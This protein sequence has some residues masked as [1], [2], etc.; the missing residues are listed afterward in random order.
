[1]EE[2]SFDAFDRLIARGGTTY[3][4]DALDRVVARNGVGGF[5]YAGL[6]IEP[7]SD[8]A[9]V[10]GR[11]PG[12]ELLAWSD[13]DTT[14]LAVSDRHG[15]VIGGLPV[16]GAALTG[17]RAYDP[18]GQVVD[19]AG[20]TGIIGFQGDWTD[21]DTGMTNMG[22][23]WYDPASAAF[24]SRDDIDLPS[25]PSILTN[26]YTYGAGAPTNFIDPD[27][28]IPW[29]LVLLALL[30]RG[31]SGCT[32][33][34]TIEADVQL[35]PHYTPIP[36]Y[37]DGNTWSGSSQHNI[38]RTSA[39]AS[40]N[41]GPGSQ[42]IGGP[43]TG[44]RGY[45]IP[46]PPP[47]PDPAIWARERNRDDAIENPTPMPDGWDD[48]W[49]G[50]G[51]DAPVSSSPSVPA[52]EV[53]DLFDRV[54]DV[55]ESYDRLYRDLLDSAGSLITNI[56]LHDSA[57]SEVSY[58]DPTNLVGPADSCD[59]SNSFAAGTEVLMADGSTKPIED[60]EVGDEVLA[61]DPTTG[62]TSVQPV[63]ATIVGDGVKHLVDITITTEDGGT[64]TI[65]ATA[66]HP[67]WV[68]DL[69][70]WVNA[71]DLEPGHRFET[72]DHRD[73]SV[74][75][76]DAY[77]APRQVRNLTIDRLH[78]YYVVAGRTQ[79]LVHN[80]G[81]CSDWSPRYE[82][83]GDLA[84]RYT[85]GQATRD[86]ASQWYHEELSND[87]LLDSINNADEGDGIFVSRGGTILGGHH[88]WDEVL[89]R[90]NDGRID[91]GTSIRV[92]VY[93]GGW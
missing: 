73:A 80:S 67:F 81:P 25:S 76:V 56:S 84:E 91:P 72:A 8:G 53:G 75:A 17:S 78:T 47:P 19:T 32:T 27:G 5:S 93:S 38:G 31:K 68:A 6:S 23:R 63:T 30:C 29:W 46:L 43:A 71:E 9:S 79:V 50:N 77:D 86:P 87:E 55:A 70:A 11:G 35:L 20:S 7:V 1:M 58:T 66:E 39:S 2:F 65:T 26:R 41:R 14:A 74:T 3:D 61:A 83:A 60:V 48:P 49:F 15:D 92:D 88:R 82:R 51:P 36:D 85:E 54:E 44:W 45:Q 33:S 28:H 16:T 10:F 69:N 22:A 24:L 89:T 42:P 59:T 21:P 40:G 37:G 34:P 64:D 52:S 62:D 4:Y 18:F 13:A 90:I 12:D 57:P